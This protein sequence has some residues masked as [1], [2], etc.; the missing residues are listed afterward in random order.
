MQQK[1][2]NKLRIKRTGKNKEPDGP[3]CAADRP[4][5][6]SAEIEVLLKSTWKRYQFERKVFLLSSLIYGAIVLALLGLYMTRKQVIILTPPQIKEKIAI[7][8][9]TAAEPYY[10]EMALFLAQLVGN[11]AP[12]T[13]DYALKV[14]SSYLDPSVYERVSDSLAD[15]AETIKQKQTATAFYP[16]KIG[17]V[18][19][20]WYVVGELHKIESL[21]DL[22]QIKKGGI[23][24]Y[25][26]G[27]KIRSYRLY[28]VKFKQ[29]TGDGLRKALREAKTNKGQR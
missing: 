9:T 26:I 11:L 14:F 5:D 15:T 28:V 20:T 10:K 12:N 18:G 8:G 3:A 1:I 4:I 21:K 7:S 22:G 16:T 19:E 29:L 2:L 13:V 27:F 24:T 6:G 23:I 25:E 17:K